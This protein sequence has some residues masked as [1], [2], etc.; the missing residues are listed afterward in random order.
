[1][2]PA[3]VVA[4]ARAVVRAMAEIESS[5]GAVLARANDRLSADLTPYRFVTAVVAFV[6]GRTGAVDWASAGHG[7]LLVRPDPADGIELLDAPAPPLGIDADLGTATG[8]PVRLAPG[9]E[10]LL[11]SDGVF[12]AFGADEQMFG[13]ARV[14]A[15]ADT[16]RD[17]A[18]AARI[19]AIR[20]AVR[21]WQGHDDPTDDQT[22]VA[23]RRV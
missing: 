12:E 21:A 20:T 17:A 7:P 13:P 15:A 10:L 9:G 1:M 8:R 18:P 6:D 3:I 14:A 22:V 4:Q 19:T 23:I 11:V 2:A 16:D 5:A